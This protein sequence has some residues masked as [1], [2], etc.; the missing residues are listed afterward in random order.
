[1]QSG[2]TKLYLAAYN[3]KGQCHC[4]R[5]HNIKMVGSKVKSCCNGELINDIQVTIKLVNCPN[6]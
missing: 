6:A 3:H 4:Y 1:M 2:F 5:D